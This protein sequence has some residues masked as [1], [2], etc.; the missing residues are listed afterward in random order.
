MSSFVAQVGPVL[1]FLLAITVVAEI[2]QLAGV[3]DVAG[4]AAVV[5]GRGRVWA[6]WLLTVA[7]AC[8]STVLLSLDTTAVLLTPVVLAAAR[9][10]RAAPLP[11][12]MTT[13]WLAN[14]ASLLLPVSNLSNLLAEYHF[15]AWGGVHG[16]LSTAWR[17]ALVA[18]AVTVALLALLHGRALFG[19]GRYVIAPPPRVQDRALL[20]VAGGVCVALCPAFVSGLPPALP[21]LVGA[22]VL[23][24]VLA[25]RD[26]GALRRIAVPWRMV[27]VLAVVFAAVQGLL[28]AGLAAVVASAAG[29]GGG[30]ADL[31]RLAALGAA[32][33]NGV[34]NLPAYLALEPAALG[35]PQRMIA[36]LVGVNM[37]PV[38]TL[39]A[40]LATVLWRQRCAR[41]GLQIPLG[42][43]AWQGLLLAV[44]V[45][46]A[47]ALA[48]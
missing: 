40:S 9:R 23:V 3:F 46:C 44:C 25:V 16:Y 8:V 48:I 5:A 37:G 22:V 35:S 33:A 18:I 32:A 45:V 36:L 12:A 15:R 47:A 27:L 29:T 34:N 38:V 2:A 6:L 20:W 11:F 31:L 28:H 21:A 24:G 13:V 14:T 39:W 10:V 4:N 17:P 19:A 42:R 1:V 30:P 7:L 26:P 41:A 43:F